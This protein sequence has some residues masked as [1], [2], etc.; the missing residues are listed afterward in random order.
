MFT[1]SPTSANSNLNTPTTELIQ[2][3]DTFG[4]VDRVVQRAD[5][6]G[7]S[8]SASASWGEGHEVEPGQ[9]AVPSTASCIKVL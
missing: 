7:S 8:Q 3:A 6:D 2:R 5:E 9:G 4:E 1:A